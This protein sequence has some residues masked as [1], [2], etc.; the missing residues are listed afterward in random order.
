VIAPEGSIRD[1][2]VIASAD[3]QA[4]SL[5]FSTYRYFLH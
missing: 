4:I 5:V 2:E 3:A 1:A